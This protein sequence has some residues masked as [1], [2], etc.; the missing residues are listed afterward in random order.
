M[1]FVVNL[2]QFPHG[3]ELLGIL[4]DLNLCWDKG[5]REIV[6]DCDSIEAIPFILQGSS[7]SSHLFC[8]IISETSYPVI[9]P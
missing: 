9:A 8:D 1:A 3:S 6:L 7:S 4:N 5:L 2:S